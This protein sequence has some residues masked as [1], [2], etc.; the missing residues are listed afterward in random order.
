M[1]KSTRGIMREHPVK[2]RAKV[3][4]NIPKEE[5]YKQSILRIKECRERFVTECE[6]T[7]K[8]DTQ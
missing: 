2:A 3:R 7:E 5:K 8:N 4:V 1:T 6:G